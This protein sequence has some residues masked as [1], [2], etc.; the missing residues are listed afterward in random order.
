MVFDEYLIK[1][2]V[3][4]R[5]D[6]PTKG[7]RYYDLQGLYA[8][9]V[10]FHM[11]VDALVQRYL[12]SSLTH[13][14]ANEPF[15]TAIGSVIAYALGKPLLLISDYPSPIASHSQP[16]GSGYPQ[17]KVLYLDKSHSLQ[18]ARVL[19]LDDVVRS[20]RSLTAASALVRCA[21]GRVTDAACILIA[22]GAGG[23]GSASELD[24]NLSNLIAF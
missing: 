6:F 3:R 17:E 22:A 12:E 10:A 14:A 9:P 15:G 23:V 20:G 7:E 21:G 1:S 5:D 18:D 13:I 16:T 24:I 19:L 8:S 4:V 11:V 2:K